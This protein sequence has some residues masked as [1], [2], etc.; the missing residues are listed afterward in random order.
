MIV[1]QIKDMTK[2]YIADPVL[3]QINLE[4]QAGQRIGLVGPNGAGKS[5]L[6]RCIVGQLQ[7]DQ[8]EIIW[9]KGTT[10]G[11]L[12][13]NS[14]LD[15]QATMWDELLTVFS[16]F[17]EEE[18][19]LRQM[20]KQMSDPAILQRE[21]E[22]RALLEQYAMRSE[23]FKEDGGYAFEAKVR[24]ILSGLGFSDYDP[25]T[26][27]ITSLSG[28]Q[29]TRLALGKLL[30]TEPDLL[31][32]D[33]PTNYLDIETLSWLEQY[34]QNYP[35]AILVVSHDRYFLDR[36]VTIIYEI[37][38]TKITRYK[39]NYTQ[40]IN[41]KEANLAQKIKS[42]EMHQQK[43]EEMKQF[44]QKNLA[45]ASTTKRAQ[46]RRKMLEKMEPVDKPTTRQPTVSIN[47]QIKKRSGYEV[48]HVNRLRLGYEAE[49]ILEDISFSVFREERIALVGPNGIGKSTLLKSVTGQIKP[50]NGD[51]R[52]GANVM[53]GYYDQEQ[54]ELDPEKT[55]L[56][57][58]WDLY[59]HLNLTDVRNVL[60]R[61]LF[62]GD[63]VEKKVA[64]LSGGEKARL[65]L[66]ILML[67]E[68]NFLLLDEPTNHLDIYS[69]EALEEA[70]QDY[71]GTILF[72]SHDR[73]FLNKMATRV[74]ELSSNQ[75]TSYLGNYDDYIQKKSD[76]LE[77]NLSSAEPQ[78]KVDETDFELQKKLKKDRRKK[79]R[80]LEEVEK[81]IEIHE[82]QISKLEEDLCSP[83]VYQNHQLSIEK[84]EQLHILKKSLDEL[85][86]EWDN[87]LSELNKG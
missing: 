66:S 38:Q 59:P 78:S 36:L 49:P 74:I 5:T 27:R 80:R 7:P 56:N 77:E 68:A 52:L 65:S 67:K 55:V 41:Q 34:L 43:V 53:V 10:F 81:E 21:E 45:R 6:L 1:L 62:R 76:L 72:V 42:Y 30:L 60:G 32:L 73:Y 37:Q 13:Q 28:G 79:E 25:H 63:E 2:S 33:E 18:K 24:G 46:S 57:Q 26:T 40:F 9:G 23:K 8:G 75:A 35:G 85:Y 44:I 61:F 20:E 64:E 3:S 71:P 69:K 48:L 16:H 82:Q 29:K 70:L 86:L 4:I 11:Y 84:N 22:Y 19:A 51:I 39:G 87:L 54:N 14:G 31:I 83:E 50:W 58:L 17:L 47:F 12:A 15:S